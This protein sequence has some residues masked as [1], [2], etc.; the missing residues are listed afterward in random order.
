VE[1]KVGHS[2]FVLPILH[3][4]LS[5]PVTDPEHRLKQ[6]DREP[7]DGTEARMQETYSWSGDISLSTP[8]TDPEHRLKQRDREPA[9]GTE[10]RMQETYSW[11]GGRQTGEGE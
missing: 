7:A 3:I 11:S 4:S 8:V 1:S 2:S 6:R 5:T 10:A 9:D